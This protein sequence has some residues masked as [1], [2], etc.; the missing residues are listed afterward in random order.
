VQVRVQPKRSGVF[1]QMRRD[2]FVVN[3]VLHVSTWLVDAQE[4]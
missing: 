3:H 4:G 2:L 1:E